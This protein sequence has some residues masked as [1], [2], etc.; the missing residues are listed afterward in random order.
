MMR[1][2]LPAPHLTD[3]AECAKRVADGRADA[4]MWHP[5]TSSGARHAVEVCGVCPVRLPCLRYA[6]ESGS[7]S[8][9]WG[10]RYFRAYLR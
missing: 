5:K 8:G 10:G 1:L 3:N 6:I 2:R 9:V 7:V 4:D